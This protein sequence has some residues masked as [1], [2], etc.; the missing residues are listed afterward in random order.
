V[1]CYGDALINVIGLPTNN[2]PVYNYNSRP[3]Q[4]TANC[5]CVCVCESAIKTF[6]FNMKWKMNTSKYLKVKK[7]ELILMA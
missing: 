1:L 2:N 3:S 4:K 5:V 6:P 7:I